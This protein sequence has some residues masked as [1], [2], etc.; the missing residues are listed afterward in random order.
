[1]PVMMQ[2]RNLPDEVHQRLKERAA[3][4]RMSLS[5]YVADQ[6]AKHVAYRSNR[7]IIE[8]FR[9]RN[10]GLSLTG[11]TAAESIHAAREENDAKFDR[12]AAERKDQTS[13]RSS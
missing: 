13:T 12:I 10:P 7:Q 11:E 5:D 2:V 4:A 3:E 8:D 6:L 1:M 9:R